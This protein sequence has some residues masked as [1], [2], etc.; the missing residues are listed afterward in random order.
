MT[1]SNSFQ[2]F[3]KDTIL[4]RHVKYSHHAISKMI[5]FSISD[6]DVSFILAN[7]ERRINGRGVCYM[8]NPK[9]FTSQGS[10][11]NRAKRLINTRVFT[12]F[13]DRIVITVITDRSKPG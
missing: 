11:S 5:L 7:G 9:G 13:D 12:S 8:L 4:K 10:V 3:N 6:K 2:G 1:D